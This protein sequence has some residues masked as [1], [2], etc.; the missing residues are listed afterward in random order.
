MNNKQITLLIVGAVLLVVATATASTY[1]AK[2][3]PEVVA[4]KAPAPKKHTNN[5]TWN[6]NTPPQPQPAP[7]QQAVNCNDGN[8]AGKAVGGVGGG[9]L[10]SNVGKGKGKTAATIGGT[11]GGAYLGGELIPLNNVT[12][13]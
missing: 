10:A 1:L 3:E 4:E 9:I 6:S 11:L 7:Q 12:C 2:K 8:I 13:R 5:I